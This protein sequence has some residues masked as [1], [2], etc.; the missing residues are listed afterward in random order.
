MDNK[1]S[2]GSEIEGAPEE[3]PCTYRDI[4]S[5]GVAGFDTTPSPCGYPVAPK[6]SYIFH[7]ISMI[8]F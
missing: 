3:L 8:T 1:D 7:G 4:Q 6:V 2:I 5:N